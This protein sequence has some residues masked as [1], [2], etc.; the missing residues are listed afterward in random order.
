[1]DNTCIDVRV[2][3]ANYLMFKDDFER[4]RVELVEIQKWVVEGREDYETE[5]VTTIGKYLVEVEEFA[6]S[7]EVF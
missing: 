1:M 2:Q 5:T 6:L 7:M 3:M 4:A